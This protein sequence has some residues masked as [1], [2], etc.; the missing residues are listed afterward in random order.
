M[1]PPFQAFMDEHRTDV[2]RVLA[3]V[4]GPQ[5]ADDCLQETFLAALSAYPD[6]K[7]ARNLRGWVMTIAFRKAIDTHRG[8]RRR[9]VPVAKVHENAV[10]EIAGAAPDTPDDDLW[11]AVRS[12][13]PMQRAAV[14]YRYVS[15]LP[16]K[17]IADAIGC[18]EDSARQNVRMGLRRLREVLS[19]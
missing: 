3:A 4:A 12:L 18:S 6:L 9:P 13:P 1:L 14:A 10:P 5:E 11:N 16:Y 7:D 8:R 17:D 15:D 19:E 2:W